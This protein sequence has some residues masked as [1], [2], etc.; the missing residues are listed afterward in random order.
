MTAGLSDDTT[1]TAGAIRPDLRPASEMSIERPM[2]TDPPGA[3][4][5]AGWVKADAD[6]DGTGAG[7][8]GRVD[9]VGDDG[10]PAWRQT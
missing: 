8:W 10:E 2:P 7:G 1:L 5:A 4:D 9:D 6:T 3:R